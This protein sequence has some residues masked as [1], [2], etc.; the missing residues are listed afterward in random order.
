MRYFTF[1]DKEFPDEVR[2]MNVD[3]NN[4]KIKENI[5]VYHKKKKNKK[6]TVGYMTSGDK[7][8]DDILVFNNNTN[9][10]CGI[11]HKKPLF[12]KI[13][14]YIRINRIDYVAI[15][16]SVMPQLISC[17]CLIGLLSAGALFIPQGIAALQTQKIVE[18]GGTVVD[19]VTLPEEE[20][21]VYITGK[22]STNIDKDNPYL[23]LSNVEQNKG[24]FLV[25]EVFKDGENAGLY[26]SDK[27]SAGNTIEWNVYNCDVLEDGINRL[28]Y[29]VQIYDENGNLIGATRVNDIV[30]NIT[31]E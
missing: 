17:I 10:H 13:S 20:P 24:I 25:Y 7:K 27:I 8:T 9:T 15:T 31:R 11:A 6:N 19:E 26:K 14:G 1:K 5:P 4:G 22:L 29:D 16:K 30:V 21:T 12:S 23:I 18:Q 28:H 2:K 3:S